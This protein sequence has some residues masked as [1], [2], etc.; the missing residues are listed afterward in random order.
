MTDRQNVR[1]AGWVRGQ[2]CA[3]GLAPHGRGSGEFTSSLLS[4]SVRHHLGTPFTTSASPYLA[5]AYLPTGTIH[6]LTSQLLQDASNLRVSF[7]LPGPI[8]DLASSM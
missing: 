4:N 5:F 1:R 2:A 7:T 8:D 6:P 3:D